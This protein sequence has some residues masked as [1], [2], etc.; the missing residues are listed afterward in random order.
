MPVPTTS[1]VVCAHTMRRLD[2]TVRCV[3]AVLAQVPA[4][5]EVVVVVD[6]NDELRAALAERLPPAVRIVGSVG[7]NGL[8]TARNVGIG[9]A[10]GAVIAFVDDDALPR[11][12]WLAALLEP[13]ADERVVATGGHAEPRWEA[14]RPEWFPDEFLWVVGCSY[15]GMVADG[16]V[17]N[18]I[19][20]NMAFRAEAFARAGVFD[21]GIGRLG[22]RPLGCEET[23]LCIRV[24]RELPGTEVMAVSRA[25]VDHA[26]TAERVTPR[27]FLDR[28]WSEGLS[29]ALV[30][31]LAA[32][33]ALSSERAH[34]ART[35]PAGLAHALRQ[36]VRGP[37]RRGALARGGALS[38]GLAAATAGYAAG[39]T[40]LRAR[41]RPPVS[42]GQ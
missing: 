35:I 36:V 42:G 31:Q 19:G 4:P 39:R 15:R 32:G 33:D 22:S 20:C 18:V 1:V 17:R 6:H 29:K 28:C 21:P 38:G 26:V 10:A 11:S 14:P 41:L 30:S 12:G 34:A 8:S 3:R 23:E 27:Y 25:V 7:P 5:D 2:V 40:V 13:F 24:R 16:P 37:H 9:H